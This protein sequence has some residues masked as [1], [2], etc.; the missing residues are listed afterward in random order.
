MEEAFFTEERRPELYWYSTDTLSNTDYPLDY[1][2]ISKAQQK[3][4]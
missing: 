1:S 4:K 3:D 2:E